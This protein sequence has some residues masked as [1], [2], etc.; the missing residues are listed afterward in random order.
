MNDEELPS[1]PA[2]K[3]VAA[4]LNTVALIPAHLLP[5]LAGF[6]VVAY[7]ARRLG[8]T[9]LGEYNTAYTWYYLLV[10][11]A[12]LGLQG[13]LIRRLARVGDALVAFVVRILLLILA[14]GALCG[15]VM[16]A[17]GRI[18][19]HSAITQQA[20]LLLAVTMGLT[21]A[22]PVL[23]GIFIAQ[24]QNW[25]VLLCETI[26][27]LLRLVISL[28]LIQLGYGVVWLI[29]TFIVSRL[30]A[31]ALCLVFIRRCGP[32]TWRAS[33]GDIPLLGLLRQALPF[34][35]IAWLNMA[36][37]RIGLLTLAT[38][39]G[40]QAVG[41]FTAANKLLQNLQLIPES[42]LLALFPHLS[43]SFVQDRRDFERLAEMSVRYLLVSTLLIIVVL[44]LT[45]GPVL[46]VIYQRSEFQQARPLLYILTISLLPYAAF[47][48]LL[49]LMMAAD[50]EWS[51][52]KWM[53]VGTVI[54]AVLNGFLVYYSSAV[55]LAISTVLTLAGFSGA[56]AWV[57]G[58]RRLL[59]T[60]LL[61][62]RRFALLL[63]STAVAGAVGYALRSF[64]WLV[65]A[66]GCTLAYGGLL[67]LFKV[68]LP[69][70]VA[71]L[72]TSRWQRSRHDQDE[73]RA[74]EG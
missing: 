12:N 5:P 42:L 53:A 10:P 16:W 54:S 21:S 4:G 9:A 45:A 61:D 51:L 29:G 49:R 17:G 28:V 15:L 26:E 38:I 59:S 43:H 3:V 66:V 52:M 62:G 74:A 24:G 11:L 37:W 65:T 56:L 1:P 39:D 30:I 73:N 70:E 68:V 57:V 67:L 6:V 55:G 48:F 50:R 36:Y 25:I 7:V 46:R 19:G 64:G 44:V 63:L 13:L 35:V 23:H 32:L 47:R 8:A 14:S 22:V 33:E 58:R 60:R 18:A 31:L 71:L 2:A 34:A 27:V 69:A 41:I 72:T 20:I 40:E